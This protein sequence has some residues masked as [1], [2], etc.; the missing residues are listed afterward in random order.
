MRSSLKLFLCAGVTILAF[1]AGYVLAQTPPP[2]ACQIP[3]QCQSA[4]CINENVSGG[5]QYTNNNSGM[6]CVPLGQ[7]L[8][9]TT[10]HMP[11][12]SKFVTCTG[13]NN[14]VFCS[15]TYYICDGPCPQ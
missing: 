15:G 13:T 6:L 14:G 1:Y 3:A 11:D 5:C 2:Q 9:N 4:S 8:G 10:C 12:A 7:E